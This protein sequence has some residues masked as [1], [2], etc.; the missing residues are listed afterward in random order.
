MAHFAKISTQGKVIAVHV[1]DNDKCLNADGVEDESV[2]QNELQ[3]L[4]GWP[5]LMWVQTSYNTRDGKYYNSDGTLAEDQSKAFRGTYACIG[6]DWDEEN[7]IFWP[8]KPYASWTKNF[9]KKIWVAPID[10]PTTWN[11]TVDGVVKTLGANWDDTNQRW[12]GVYDG[13]SGG[14]E[15]SHFWN[16]STLSWDPV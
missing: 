4:H 16:T 15:N 8:K 13:Y 11:V 3:R 10:E 14:E 7:Q 12:V 6:F 1:L 5:S 2:G 9:T